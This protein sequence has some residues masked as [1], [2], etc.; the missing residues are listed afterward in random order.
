MSA[1]LP[2]PYEA[3]EFAK[4]V[5]LLGRY[6]A[7]PLGVARLERLLAEPRMESA[8][9]AQQDLELVGEAAA[10]L[11]SAGVANQRNVA[12]LPRFGGIEDVRDP[13]G[14][15]SRP[16]VFPSMRLRSGRS[17]R[18]SIPRSRS[19]SRCLRPETSGPGCAEWVKTC[20]I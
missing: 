19:A 1:M 13:V 6:A 16:M 4:V 14:A 20:P 18:C 2:N 5:A 15:A 7:T 3:L 12:P 10:W 11:R 9:A 17:C 8:Q